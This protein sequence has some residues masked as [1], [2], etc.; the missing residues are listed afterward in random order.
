MHRSF[1]TIVSLVTVIAL[2]AGPC[3]L[4]SNIPD[5]WNVGPPPASRPQPTWAPDGSYALI[6]ISS[7][8]PFGPDPAATI[9][10]LP[11][12]GDAESLGTL[13]GEFLF[14]STSNEMWSADRTQL[15]YTVPVER[16]S[17]TR[18][19]VIGDVDGS[20]SVTYATGDLGV[21]AWAA[22][23]DRFAFWQDSRAEIMMGQ[24]GQAPVPI[25][26]PDSEAT[27]R[28]VTVRWTGADT[29]VYG[30]TDGESFSIW[31]QT[32]GSDTLL[33]AEGSGSYPDI[34]VSW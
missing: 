16:E 5:V 9:W 21:L 30:V 25:P 20:H 7:S 13:H 18:D 17:N 19:L 27:H 12:V 4:C 28:V 31:R 15:A 32:V 14:I 23:G 24:I 29:L 8:E 22:E 34:D 1:L 2:L 11:L 26:M 6:A 33:L 3:C 10:R